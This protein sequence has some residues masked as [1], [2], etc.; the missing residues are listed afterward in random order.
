[1]Q[2]YLYPAALQ[3]QQTGPAVLS[4]NNALLSAGL[5]LSRTFNK[6]VTDFISLPTLPSLVTAISISYWYKQASLPGAYPNRFSIIECFATVGGSAN[7][8]VNH[9]G[10]APETVALTYSTTGPNYVAFS[11]NITAD[12]GVWHN[13]VISSDFTTA[14]TSIYLDGVSLTVTTTGTPGT[15]ETAMTQFRIG[16]FNGV[17]DPFDGSLADLV[18]WST[19]LTSGNVAS[20]NTPARG[21]TVA[22][23]SIVGNW[24][25][26][27]TNPEHDYSSNANHGIPSFPT[28]SGGPP[29]LPSFGSNIK[30]PQ[31]LSGQTSVQSFLYPGALQP[32]QPSGA[33][34]VFQRQALVIPLLVTGN[35][36]VTIPVQ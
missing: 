9:S 33:F 2:N 27:G 4:W 34:M 10:S 22:S 16:V 11:A 14:G 3:P 30:F 36:K 6:S 32:L 5:N 20:I 25:I 24:P 26:L 31:H 8:I 28:V 18:L 19:Q 12:T 15:P 13:I 17:Q 21:G 23:G 1:M 35:I 29:L 7:Y